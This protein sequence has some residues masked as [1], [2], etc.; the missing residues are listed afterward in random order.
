MHNISEGHIQHEARAHGRRWADLHDGYFSDPRMSAGYVDAISRALHGAGATTIVDLGGGTGYV[1]AELERIGAT[2]GLGVVNVDLSSAQLAMVED[3]SVHNVCRSVGE[4]RREE[5]CPRDRRALFIMRSVAHY[6]GREGLA[7][8]FRHLRTQA[9]LGETFVHQTGCFAGRQGADCIN[10]LYSLMGTTKWYPT[11]DQLR[12]V[13]GGVG[14]DVREVGDAPS[15]PL[16]T[17]DLAFRYGLSP[18]ACR[19]IRARIFE[20]HGEIPDIFALTETG[21]LAYLPYRVFT[22]VAA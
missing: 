9:E 18:E 2:Q 19:L 16:S 13:L 8:L 5:V 6:F 11:E 3:P 14:W 17:E 4:V 1:L 7:P 22:C 12:S 20:C 21:F 10:L 15:L